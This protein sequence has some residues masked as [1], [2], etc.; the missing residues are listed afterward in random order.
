MREPS[1]RLEEKH[2]I[3]PPSWRANYQCFLHRQEQG[4]QDRTFQFQGGHA[5][6][7]AHSDLS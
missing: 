1:E 7:K 2:A 4:G 6:Y 3:N 5:N